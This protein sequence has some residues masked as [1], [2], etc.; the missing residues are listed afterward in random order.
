MNGRKIMQ[1]LENRP[2]KSQSHSEVRQNRG[3]ALASSHDGKPSQLQ[4]LIDSSPAMAVQRKLMEKITCTPCIRPQPGNEGIRTVQRKVTLV[5]GTEQAVRNVALACMGKANGIRPSPAYGETPSLF[6]G[7]EYPPLHEDNLLHPFDVQT[8]HGFGGFRTTIT[9]PNQIV[10]WLMELPAAG[11]WV[12][13]KLSAEFVAAQIAQ[14]MPVPGSHEINQLDEKVIVRAQGDPSNSTLVSQIKAHEAK[15]VKNTL[16][17]V[18]ETLKPWDDNLEN[19]A[20]EIRDRT[21]PDPLSMA[22]G[23]KA[24]VPEAASVIS[25]R[26]AREIRRRDLAYHASPSGRDPKIV[27]F[28]VSGKPGAKIVDVMVRLDKV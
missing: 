21:S 15:H 24:D 1:K 26:V 27:D 6:N 19:Y 9:V 12:S 20:K 5:E 13:G 11:P 23:M 25:R 3:A 7:Q 22:L 2:E 17:V 8:T 14:D 18:T 10:S 4:S 28:S 16:D